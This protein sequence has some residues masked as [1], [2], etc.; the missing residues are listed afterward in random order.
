MKKKLVAVLLMIMV[1]STSAVLA[2]NM[3]N[4]GENT[5]LEAAYSAQDDA[6]MEEV[7]GT[8]ENNPFGET[9]ALPNQE[10]T[11]MESI[12]SSQGNPSIEQQMLLQ[13]QNGFL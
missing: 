1:L 6:V 10:E 9:E 2:V 5:V 11:V 4:Q 8:G 13:T 12:Y 3:A 7:Y